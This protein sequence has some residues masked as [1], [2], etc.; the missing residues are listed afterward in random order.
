MDHLC[1]GTI[2]IQ[3]WDVCWKIQVEPAL[4]SGGSTVGNRK[5]WDPQRDVLFFR[6]HKS[7]RLLFCNKIHQSQDRSFDF[8]ALLVQCFACQWTIPGCIA[9]AGKYS[10]I[11]SGK[12]RFYGRVR[13]GLYQLESQSFERMCRCIRICQRF[14][15]FCSCQEQPSVV[16]V[17]SLPLSRFLKMEPAIKAGNLQAM[18]E[19]WNFHWFQ[20]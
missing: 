16:W 19:I 10:T 5:K 13:Q 14:V 17:S 7:I 15:F 20:V 4:A 1:R 2:T 12:R 11:P 3:G 6:A 8:D 18:P 9:K